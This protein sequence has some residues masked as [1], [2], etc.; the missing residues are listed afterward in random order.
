MQQLAD[1]ARFLKIYNQLQFSN[2][3]LLKKPKSVADEAVGKCGLQPFEKQDPRRMN[4]FSQIP[5]P[6][7]RFC[8][9][10]LI[11]ISGIL[12]SLVIGSLK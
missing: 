1:F 6:E 7:G 5:G 3:T 11:G 9:P 12:V 2:R 8:G 4:L 10:A